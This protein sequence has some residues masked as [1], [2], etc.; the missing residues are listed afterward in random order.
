MGAGTIYVTFEA[1]AQDVCH[2]YSMNKIISPGRMT[3]I[4]DMQNA[5]CL[6]GLFPNTLTFRRLL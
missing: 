4:R 1:I 6:T 3:H 5:R 2:V